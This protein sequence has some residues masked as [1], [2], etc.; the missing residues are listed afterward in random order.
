MKKFYIVILLAI[1]V[2]TFLQFNCSSPTA[3]NNNLTLSVADV[4]CTEAWL[5]LS[6][7]SLPLPANIV[8]NKNG[9]SF[10]SLTLT[11]QDTTLCDSNLS[12][13]QAYTYQAVYGNNKSETVTAKTMDTTSSNFTFQTFTFGGNAGSS[14]F[15]DCA[16]ANDTLSYIVG[17]VYLEDSTGKPDPQPY[18]LAI[19]NGKNWALQKR[20][21]SYKILDPNSIGDTIGITVVKSLAVFDSKDIWLAAGT[22]QHWD[23]TQWQQSQGE[24]AGFSNKMWGNS[25]SILYFVGGNGTIIR[26]ANGVWQKLNSLTSLDI[27]D[28]IGYTNSNQ[29]EIYCIASDLF[30][31]NGNMVL[32]INGSQVNAVS[33]KGLPV[34]SFSS[35]WLN[36]PDKAYLAGSGIYINNHFS[37]GGTW[38]ELQPR[39]SNDYLNSIRGNDVNDIVAVGSFGEVVHFNGVRWVSYISQTGLSNGEYLSVAIKGNEI[40]AV[41]YDGAKA[42]ILMGKR[43]V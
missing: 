15:Y 39:A 17:G 25:S 20:L 18:N 1:I 40:I 22:I 16:I 32:Q 30:T 38:K 6:T 37:N 23:G 10:L 34:Y 13:N 8:V 31:A 12:P 7:G 42:V 3:P 14:A 19:Y 28:I 35:I 43:I 5:N 29:T 36:N 24:G 11:S 27:Q 9:N 26:F 33:N 4:S 21:F 41:G 2:L